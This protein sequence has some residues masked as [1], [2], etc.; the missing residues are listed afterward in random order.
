MGYNFPRYANNRFIHLSRTLHKPLKR[1]CWVFYFHSPWFKPWAKNLND[2]CKMDLSIFSHFTQSIE[3][4]H[5][6]FQFTAHGF[7]RGL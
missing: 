7:N 2:M 1:F 5:Y 3:K 6:E 4:V